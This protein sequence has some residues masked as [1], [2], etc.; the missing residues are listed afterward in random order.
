MHSVP[1]SNTNQRQNELQQNLS[2]RRSMY[3][4]TA[5]TNPVSFS[6]NT[7]PHASS[8]VS[9]ETTSVADAYTN[10]NDTGY[11]TRIN[12]EAHYPMSS[13]SHLSSDACNAYYTS[14][15]GSHGSTLSTSSGNYISS[16]TTGPAHGM[17][18]SSHSPYTIQASD[19]AEASSVSPPSSY[20]STVGASNRSIS[21][22]NR[23][24]GPVNQ[25]TLYVVKNSYATPSTPPLFFKFSSL[26]SSP[27]PPYMDTCSSSH[28]LYMD[29][30]PLC[31]ST[32]I[33]QS[34][35]T[36]RKFVPVNHPSPLP[37]GHNRRIQEQLIL[38]S[39][40]S[41]LEGHDNHKVGQGQT[42]VPVYLPQVGQPYSSCLTHS[43][44]GS[45]PIARYCFIHS[46]FFPFRF[47][48]P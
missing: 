22:S 31:T 28:P 20:V 34:P 43:R 5:N 19:S 47:P 10:Q 1:S 13:T 27:H 17:P 6:S 40:R 11:N 4:R 18:R 23:N 24:Y 29:A 21:D 37:I 8:H 36:D 38:H 33:S 30:H 12:S 3:D 16:H 46:S 15:N 32:P 25:K 2:F 41:E 35:A 9:D 45:A 42:T 39:L 48:H 14:S 7:G 26:N 44:Q